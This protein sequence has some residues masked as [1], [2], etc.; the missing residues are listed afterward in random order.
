M[1]H[2]TLSQEELELK[3]ADFIGGQMSSDEAEDFG[4]I[5]TNNPQYKKVLAEFKRMM[6]I[7]DQHGNLEIPEPSSQMDNN[8]YSLLNAETNKHKTKQKEVRTNGF[9]SGLMNFFNLPQVRKL[10][11]GFSFMVV[12]VFVGHYL[13]LLNTQTNIEAQ[14]I[15][16]KDQ[17]IQALTVLSLLDMPSANKRLMAIN[18]ASMSEAPS[19][20]IL[21]ALLVT[22]K[23]DSNVNVRLEALDVL[24][25][26]TSYETVRTGLVSAINQQKS[27][28]VQIAMAN[29]MLKMNEQDAVQPIQDLLQKTDLIEPVRE[30]L[31][32]TVNELTI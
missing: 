20:P 9:L 16:I 24:A 19:Q 22:L 32:D 11:Y 30:Q 2:K 23:Q 3:M 5:I 13:H 4:Q 12:G 15:S 28:M 25:T 1:S 7:V 31:N 10:T 29:L 6:E 18:L 21:D 27:P 26:L 8:F 17:Q 14:R